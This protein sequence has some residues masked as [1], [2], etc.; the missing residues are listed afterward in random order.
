MHPRHGNTDQ[1]D[2]LAQG[3]KCMQ[4][5]SRYRAFLCSRLCYRTPVPLPALV[6]LSPKFKASVK[7][8]AFKA[9]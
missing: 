4:V 2:D 9:F 1:A 5:E 3:L 7:I 8:W 6:N